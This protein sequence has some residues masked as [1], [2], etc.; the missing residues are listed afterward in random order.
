MLHL[1]PPVRNSVGKILATLACLGGLWAGCAGSAWANYTPPKDADAPSGSTGSSGVRGCLDASGAMVIL[2]PRSHVGQTTSTRPTVSWAMTDTQPFAM[3]VRLYQ[4]SHTGERTL[5]EQLSLETTPGFMQ[6]TLPSSQPALEPGHR[7]LWQV[8]VLC[9]PN[10]PS[11]ALVDEVE[12]DVVPLPSGLESA[13]AQV[14]NPEAQADLY[15]EAGLW[16]DAL[17]QAIAST[18]SYDQTLLQE[19][20]SIEQATP[21]GQQFAEQLRRVMVD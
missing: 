4:L 5:V 20:A 11:S 7:Y 3:Q 16:Y 19:L 13:L 15:A 14:D 6:A 2:A 17:A 8:I 21:L 9:N 10:R 18:N 1:S 12:M